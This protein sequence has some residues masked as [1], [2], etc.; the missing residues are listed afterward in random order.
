MW[1]D[2]L[3]M[4]EPFLAKYGRLFG[5][6][7][8][9]QDTA[10]QQATLMAEHAR[11]PG[12]SGLLR[13]AWDADKNAAW[14]DPKTGLSPEVWGRA[15]G[16]YLMALV[17]VLDELP[18]SHPGRAKLKALL[19]EAARGVRA[20]QDAKTGL[21]FQVLDK[22]ALAA[23][24]VETSGSGMIVYAF[25]RGAARGY[26]DADYKAVAERG[27]RGLV[28]TLSEDERGPIV[29]GAVEGMGAQKDLASYLD[30]K[31][32]TNSPHGLCALLLATTAVENAAA[33]HR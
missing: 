13:H 4:G 9:P 20:V 10:V 31:R 23:N 26:L 33:P 8:F 27:L 11:A 24:W 18:A 21:W 3:Y 5:E 19:R 14:A 32:L 28:A 6:T 2:G 22:P 15:M 12:T 29:T 17:D 7:G 16:W 25:A 1:L 30:K